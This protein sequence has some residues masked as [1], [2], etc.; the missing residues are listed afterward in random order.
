MPKNNDDDIW[1][2]YTKSIKP[3]ARVKKSPTASARSSKLKT[4]KPQTAVRAPV[5]SVQDGMTLRELPL[6]R[7]IERRLRQGEIK[8]DARLDLHGLFQDR[9]YHELQ[10][11]VA[12]QIRSGSRC[13]LIITG[14]GRGGEGVLRANL[15]GWLKASPFAPEILALRPASLRHGGAG[16]F[17]LLLRR[18]V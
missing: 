16:A 11:F 2:A 1:G 5:L 7:K 15:E 9:A 13:L 14:K 3:I 8:I 6:D 17:Y 10:N 12:R 4:E 18:R